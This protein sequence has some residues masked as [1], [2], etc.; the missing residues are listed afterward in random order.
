MLRP[1]THSPSRWAGVQA[2]PGKGQLRFHGARHHG[3]QTSAAGLRSARKTSSFLVRVPGAY[4]R[5]AWGQSGFLN[6]R[7][8]VGRREVV[9]L[10]NGLAINL[11]N[12]AAYFT[13]LCLCP[14]VPLPGMPSPPPEHSQLPSGPRALPPDPSRQ[15]RPSPLWPPKSQCAR[16]TPELG[17][18]G[19]T[20]SSGSGRPEFKSQ[21][22]QAHWGDSEEATH[23][24]LPPGPFLSCVTLGRFPDLSDTRLLHLHSQLQS[25]P[26]NL[27]LGRQRCPPVPW[28]VGFQPPPAWLSQ[29]P[30]ARR[31]T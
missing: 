4:R 17:E 23:P 28:A 6:Q 26:G 14:A 7:V 25:V 19:G 8:G 24:L 9:F 31:C 5:G 16:F 12:V 18:V 1:G 30:P 22:R 10:L 29:P 15:N 21:L 3:N 11:Q 27:L 2:Y 20:K 13:P